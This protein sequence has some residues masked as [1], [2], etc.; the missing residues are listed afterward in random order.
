MLELVFA[1]AAQWIGRSDEDI[2]AA[3]MHVRRQRVSS[4][5]LLCAYR[6]VAPGR[7]RTARGCGCLQQLLSWE[8]AGIQVIPFTSQDACRC[9]LK[10]TLCRWQELERLFPDEVKADGSLAA[11][12]KYH[13]VKTPLSVY[14]T[15]PGCEVCGQAAACG[16]HRSPPC[17]C[18]LSAALHIPTRSVLHLGF[19][20][21]VH[22]ASSLPRRSPC[23]S[24]DGAAVAA[25][26]C[27][28][29]PVSTSACGAHRRRGRRSGPRW[30]TSTCRV[31]TRSRSTLPAWRA[32][33][34]AASL[35]QRPSRR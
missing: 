25:V 24:H 7:C 30:P 34:S 28:G 31:T 26:Q 2:I 10:Q 16:R 18:L 11:I 15:V 21:T 3:T 13:V 22:R 20:S 35:P 32:P 29:V 17:T 4:C 1:P 27:E 9:V 23:A 12:E 5:T 8:Q 33:C 14:K 19:A 6:A